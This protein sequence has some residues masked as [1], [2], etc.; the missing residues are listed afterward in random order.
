MADI[1][2]L[3]SK[4]PETPGERK[5]ATILPIFNSTLSLATCLRYSNVSLF[6]ARW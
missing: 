2:K 5:A 4:G 1:L 3:Q 6:C